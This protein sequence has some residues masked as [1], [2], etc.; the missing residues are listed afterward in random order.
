MSVIGPE[1]KCSIILI[2]YTYAKS[3]TTQIVQKKRKKRW[4]QNENFQNP[5]SSTLASNF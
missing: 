3:E 5:A 4:K 2:A 1:E